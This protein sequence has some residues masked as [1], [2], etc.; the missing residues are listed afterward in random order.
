MSQSI[1]LEPGSDELALLHLVDRD[2]T[3]AGCRFPVGGNTRYLPSWDLVRATCGSHPTKMSRP[4]PPSSAHGA[5]C[6]LTS[7]SG[8]NRRRQLLAVRLEPDALLR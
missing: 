1:R 4:V 6:E 5:Q 8:S 3:D 2:P 7:A